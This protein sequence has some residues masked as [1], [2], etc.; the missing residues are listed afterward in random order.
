M[1]TSIF[2]CR[3]ATTSAISRRRASLPLS[4]SAQTLSFSHCD[5]WLQICFSRISV[6]STMPL[7]W[8]PSESCSA[9]ARSVT[10]CS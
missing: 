9:S 3:A 8:I 5:G 2:S 10:V 4:S 7:R 1:K 6:A